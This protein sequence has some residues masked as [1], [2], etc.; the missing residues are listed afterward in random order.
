MNSSKDAGGGKSVKV[1]TTIVLNTQVKRQRR[2]IQCTLAHEQLKQLLLGN[3][4][5]IK[6][7]S[8]LR[9]AQMAED[10]FSVSV[11]T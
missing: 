9:N 11:S 3:R 1:Y 4:K 10:N 8:A 2:N 5:N 7:T 6:H